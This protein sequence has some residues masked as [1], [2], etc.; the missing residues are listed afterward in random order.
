[1][2]V[3]VEAKRGSVMGWY[4]Q[5]LLHNCRPG[6]NLIPMTLLHSQYNITILPFLNT[7]NPKHCTSSPT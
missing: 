7:P 3:F 1:M 6:P 4:D 2:T 5:L